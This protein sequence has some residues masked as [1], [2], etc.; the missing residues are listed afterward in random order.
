MLVPEWERLK[1]T[2][3]SV[4][5]KLEDAIRHIDHICELAG[6]SRH[7]GIGSDLDGAF[8]KE[9]CPIDIETIAD[10]QKIGTLLEERGYKE[11]DIQNI[12]S[13]NWISFLARNW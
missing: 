12:L 10:L 6:N 2:P 1:L 9:Q 7:V 5:L 13:L 4:N 11:A 8:G 3:E